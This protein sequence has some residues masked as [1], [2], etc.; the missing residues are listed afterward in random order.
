[1]LYINLHH[2]EQIELI[3]QGR[4]LPLMEEFYSLQGEGANTGKPA[5]FIRLGGCDVG[6]YWCD[7]KESWN[8]EIHALTPIN[9]IISHILACK[10]RAVVVTGGEPL[11]YNLDAFCKAVKNSGITT[12]LETS[13]SYPLSGEWDWICLSP[14]RKKR[15]LSHIFNKADELKVIILDDL[16]FKWAE[17]C[18]AEVGDGCFRFLQPEWSRRN[19]I[20]PKIIDY[21][22]NHPEWRISLQSHKYLGIP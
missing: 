16:D 14:K 8:P 9:D 7:V 20:T 12:Y 5:Y 6:C 15:P 2:P 19:M 11:I 17:E 10:A 22:M 3:K 1:M 13:G 18:S 4:L 21:I